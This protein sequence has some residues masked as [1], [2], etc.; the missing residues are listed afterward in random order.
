MSEEEFD[1]SALAA[2][3]E[4]RDVGSAPEGGSDPAPEADVDGDGSSDADDSG[5]PSKGRLAG[6]VLPLFIAG[7]AGPS[8]S[9]FEERGVSQALANVLDG[10]TDYLLD[11]VGKDP[12]DSLG[13]A[14]K[15]GIGL[16]QMDGLDLGG[17]STSS[18]SSS[19]D[20]GEGGDPLGDGGVDAV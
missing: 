15:I 10:V 2:V 5:P 19:D 18:S 4:G 11:L 17:G 8:A 6:F 7:E 20:D 12:G 14:G 1:A 13:P 9:R 3:A 16:S